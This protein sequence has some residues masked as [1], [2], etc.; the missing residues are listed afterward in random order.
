MSSI[1]PR[2]IVTRPLPGVE[3]KMAELF[4]TVFNPEDR[5]LTRDALIAAMQDCDVLVPNVTDKIDAAMIDQAGERLKLVA[6]FGAGTDH[7]DIPALKAKGIAVTNTPD[8]F[9]HDTAD[10]TM[11]L[12]L[13]AT[14]RLSE[15]IRMVA[16]GE[17]DGWAPSRLLGR[18]LRG[19]LL[20]IVGM[21]AIGK[22]LASR[23]RAFG[24]E[25][26]Y[27]N[28]RRLPEAEETTLGV[29]FQP[30]LEQLIRTADYLSLNCPSTPETR[31]M[32]N[33][34][35]IAA[36]KPGSFV[37]NSG[38]GDLIDE[39][40]LIAA[41][42]SRHLGGAGLD[43]FVGE[44][45]IRPEFMHLKNVT[46]LPHL[47]SATVEGRTEAGEKIIRNIQAWIAGEALPDAV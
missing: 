10:I 2:V 5:A 24:M 46:A 3:P 1:K 40:A 26:A 16:A 36:M 6:N 41:L 39:P 30:D 34:E 28:R 22:E 8:V 31:G 4:D 19:K 44:P 42:E 15:G 45:N 9:T 38:R 43:V 23:A 37:I 13:N 18:N 32:L 17:W 11:A 33:A 14:R 35:R 47:G 29:R 12:I 21:G 20:G 27:N 25:I 7:L